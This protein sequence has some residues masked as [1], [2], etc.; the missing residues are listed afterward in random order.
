MLNKANIDTVFTAFDL[1]KDGFID[2]SELRRIFE[3]KNKSKEE[4][5]GSSVKCSD[6]EDRQIWKDIIK[7][8]DKDNDGKISKNEFS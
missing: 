3:D 4:E 5:L 2:M 6:E 7:E 1:N 8:V